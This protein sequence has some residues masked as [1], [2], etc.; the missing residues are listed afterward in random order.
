M[1]PLSETHH[2]IINTPLSPQID[3][4]H[5]LN[6]NSLHAE[7]GPI[8]Q[9]EHKKMQGSRKLSEI[10]SSDENATTPVIDQTPGE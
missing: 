10:I 2:H 8:D 5:N 6:L 3:H 7:H 9:E 4:E 1:G